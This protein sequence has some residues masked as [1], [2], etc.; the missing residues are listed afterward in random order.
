MGPAKPKWAELGL[1]RASVVQG[2]YRKMSLKTKL[3][4]FWGL[5]SKLCEDESKVDEVIER[6]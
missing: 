4:E 5:E 6:E 1:A 2:N 3:K